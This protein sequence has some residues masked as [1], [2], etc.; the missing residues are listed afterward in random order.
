MLAPYMICPMYY[1]YINNTV[2]VIPVQLLVD[3]IGYF[4][5]IWT[6][7]ILDIQLYYVK[8]TF[9]VHF[10]YICVLTSSSYC[11]HWCHLR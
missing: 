10:M 8:Y 6:I 4:Q 2:N 11:V 3:L 7:H 9:Y 1:Q 5:K